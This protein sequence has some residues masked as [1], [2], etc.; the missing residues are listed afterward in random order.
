MSKHPKITLNSGQELL[1][2]IRGALI[3][4]LEYAKLSVGLFEIARGN[5]V[6]QSV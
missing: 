3:H 5:H 4:P 2:R 1:I 6:I